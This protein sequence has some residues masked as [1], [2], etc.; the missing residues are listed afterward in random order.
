MKIR[1]GFVSNSS[2]SSF[3]I[4]E[5]KYASV[6]DVALE[7]LEIRTMDDWPDCPEKPM[8]IRARNLGV[9]PDTPITFATCNYDT[10]IFKEGPSILVS[11]CNN[12]PW[13]DYLNADHFGGGHDDGDFYDLERKTY[14][15]NPA[16][17]I[18]GKPVDRDEWN[19]WL[20]K[21]PDIANLLKREGSYSYPRCW[22]EDRHWCN[23]V[24]IPEGEI[25]CPRCY[26]MQK[27]P[28]MLIAS[29][30][31]HGIVTPVKKKVQLR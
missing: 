7:M 20:N 18:V 16:F 5:N 8:I 3:I 21:R 10:F 12:H 29:R 31:Y 25:V 22:A 17:D 4:S 15:W 28:G 1:A 19:N 11:T 14:F 24:K 30:E 13:W 26:V 9:D 23:P 27:R 6:F 2:S